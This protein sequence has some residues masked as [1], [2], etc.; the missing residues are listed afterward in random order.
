MAREKILVLRL[1]SAGDILQT[2]PAVKVLRQQRPDA[3]IAWLVDKRHVDLL[4]G[5][6]EVDEV[7][8][9]PRAR[10]GAGLRGARTFPRTTAEILDFSRTLRRQ[11]FHATL[12]FQGNL[13]S[14][15]WSWMSGAPLR[16][17]FGPG[18][19]KEV[20][21][22]FNTA[23]VR[24]SGKAI[25]RVRKYVDLLRGLSIQT[26]DIPSGYA[27]EKEARAA[28]FAFLRDRDLTGRD[29]VVLSPATSR[30]GRYKKWTAPQWGELAAR[31]EEECN[32]LPVYPWGPGERE[33]AEGMAGTSRGALILPE[34]ATTFAQ[35]AA[36][37][38]GAALF[39]GVD[40]A[41]MHM[42]HISG[43]PVVALF[44]PTNQTYFA[45]FLCA[46]ALVRAD[47]PCSPCRTR[48]CDDIRCMADITV[49]RV[50]Q[51]AKG[52][53]AQGTRGRFGA[54]SQ[55]A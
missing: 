35:L 13:K 2:L 39:I 53:L 28:F 17:G 8:V 22:L 25:H 15:F 16:I 10:W 46:N 21:F 30:F 27:V 33:E 38:E 11:G 3:H 19:S 6:P 7:L 34:E 31:L 9:H 51:A 24:P 1:S 5:Q 45:P 37:L 52:L 18:D 47:L 23:F 50:L 14:G 49:D 26:D 32:A 43:T 41:P 44:G 55:G 4:E 12:D 36:F 29:L 20:N 48:G 40:S 42:A 54:G